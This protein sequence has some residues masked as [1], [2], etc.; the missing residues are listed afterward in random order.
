MS[1]VGEMRL[2]DETFW[3]QFWAP[4]R[5]PARVNR[6]ASFDRCMSRVFRRFLA[7]GQGKT[8]IEVGAAPGRWLVYF[9]EKMGYAVDGIE[10]IPSSCRKT[11]ENLAACGTD[12]RIFQQDFFHNDLPRHSYDV[13]LSLGFIEHFTDP[14]P[15]VEGHTALLKPGGLLVLGVPNLRGLHGAVERLTDRETLAAHNTAVMSVPFLKGLAARHALSPLWIGYTG[16]LSPG[17]ISVAGDRSAE[18]ETGGLAATLRRQGV[19]LL[20]LVLRL[21]RYVRSGLPPLDY[22]NGPL[23]SSY[24]VAVYRY[25]PQH[26]ERHEAWNEAHNDEAA[27]EAGVLQRA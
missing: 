16:G 15:A 10:Y 11:E 23:I 13:V 25:T 18:R 1:Q 21:L 8:L 19:L 24:L 4:V 22:L 17:L 3:E 20:R 9:R 5:I 12:G 2:T 27:R 6:L 14:D 7:D 26:E